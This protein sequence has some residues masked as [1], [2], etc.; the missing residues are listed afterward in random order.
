MMLTWLTNYAQ[1]NGLHARLPNKFDIFMRYHLFGFPFLWLLLIKFIRVRDASDAKCFFLSF[2]SS[3]FMYLSV[4]ILGLVHF[5]KLYILYLQKHKHKMLF[6]F[7][8][9]LSLPHLFLGLFYVPFH[10]Y[11]FNQNFKHVQLMQLCKALMLQKIY[12]QTIDGLELLWFKRV[13]LMGL[14]IFE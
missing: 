11:F 14:K 2:R 8:I 5:Y 10:S 7:D 13:S 4:H 12:G 1:E 9:I 3:F 6:W